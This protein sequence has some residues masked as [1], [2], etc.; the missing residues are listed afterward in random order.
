MW[1]ESFYVVALPVLTEVSRLGC[2]SLDF[3]LTT[4]LPQDGWGATEFFTRT[5]IVFNFVLFES[6]IENKPHH[7]TMDLL[8]QSTMKNGAKSD[9]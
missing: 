4:A 5:M 8:A 1:R 2:L 7:L 3:G 9:T 6:A